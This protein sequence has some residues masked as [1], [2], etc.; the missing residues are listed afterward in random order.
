MTHGSPV[1]LR[2]LATAEVAKRPGS[3]P[4]HAKLA[5]VTEEGQ[6]GLEGAAAEDVVAAVGAVSGNVAESPDRLLADIGFRAREELDEYGDGTSLDNDLG[7]GG[8]ARG[9]VRQGPGGLELN[10]RVGGA[11][12]FDETAHDTSLDD[13]LNGRVALLG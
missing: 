2:G 4:E 8:R 1:G 12:E 11:E 3:I 10:E 5:A 9:D 13:L 6:E 7:L